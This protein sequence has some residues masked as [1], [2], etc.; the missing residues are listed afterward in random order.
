MAAAESITSTGYSSRILRLIILAPDIQGAIWQGTH[1]TTLT[2]ADLMEP[3]PWVLPRFYGH[4]KEAHGLVR[5]SYKIIP[6][7]QFCLKQGIR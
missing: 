3:F 7:Y 1:P 5:I 4:V 2:L 6:E